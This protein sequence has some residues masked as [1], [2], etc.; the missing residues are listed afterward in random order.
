MY[1]KNLSRRAG[2]MSEFEDDVTALIAWAKSQ[3]AFMNDEKLSVRVGSAKIKF[4]EHQMSAK[5]LI[6]GLCVE[7]IDVCVRIA[8]CCTRRTT[9]I[10]IIASFV[11]KLGT[12][13]PRSEILTTRT[14]Y[15]ILKYFPFTP[16][17]QRLYASE[18]TADYMTWHANHQMEDGS[19]C[20][21][22]D[23]YA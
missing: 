10:W 18:A 14:P 1:E 2:F 17:L 23:T 11:E 22:S 12:S 5:K 6:L 19:M 13:Q 16:R 9:L 4:L 3:H 7:K 8:A 15:A 20:H 21:W